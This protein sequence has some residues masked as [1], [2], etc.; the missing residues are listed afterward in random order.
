MLKLEAQSAEAAT[1]FQIKT[2]EVRKAKPQWTSYYHGQLINKDDFETITRY[3]SASAA[4]RERI[5]SDPQLRDKTV[6][7]LI[8][9]ITTVAKES[10]L[11]YTATL[12]DDMLVENK[13]RVALF[14]E[15]G[16]IFKENIYVLF[17]RMLYRDDPFTVHQVSRIIAKLACW[18]A[19]LMPDKEVNDYFMW[20][21]ENLNEK[22]PFKETLC[23]C[24]QMMLRIDH[25]RERFYKSSGVER[26]IKFLEVSV[27]FQSKDQIQYQLVCCLWL[28]TFNTEISQKIETTY[29]IIPIVADILNATEKEK[30]KRICL[31]LFRN[32]IEK[33]DDLDVIRANSLRLLQFKLKKILELMNQAQISDPEIIDDVEFLSKKLDLLVNDVSSFDEYAAEV[34]SS[35]LNWS[36]VHRSD[37][38]WRENAPRL[39]ENNF[40]LIKHLVK[41]LKDTATSPAVL[42]IAAFDIGEYV[43]YY[44]RGKS[45]IEQFDGKSA[46]MALLTHN[47]A[48]VKHQSLLCVQKLMVH[49]WEYLTK[50]E[51]SAPSSS[52]SQISGKILESKA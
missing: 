27:S 23:R 24:L 22:N 9:L 15:Y 35:R 16:R 34:A 28:L 31:A 4:D 14:H 5:L 29:S 42:E 26:I 25:Y 47:D 40:F 45:V 6:R 41:L 36:P 21:K 20:I 39:N 8:N 17:L 19:T 48:N 1:E 32:L 7:T 2:L 44:P 13:Q 51:A 30:V 37:K 11:Q 3:D 52:G 12:I 18:S 46:V 49:H 50:A 33:P 10:A 38:F 43:R